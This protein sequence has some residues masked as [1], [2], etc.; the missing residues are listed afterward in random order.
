MKR[1]ELGD[2]VTRAL[3]EIVGINDD[4]PAE[5]AERIRKM[6]EDDNDDGRDD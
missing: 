4:I 3:L 1:F 2:D 6:R 5:F